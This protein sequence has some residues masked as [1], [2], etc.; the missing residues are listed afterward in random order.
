M[1][2]PARNRNVTLESHLGRKDLMCRKCRKSQ[3]AWEL[4][5]I[6]YICYSTSHKKLLVSGGSRTEPFTGRLSVVAGTLIRFVEIFFI[7]AHY[8]Q[9]S[10]D[11]RT[12]ILQ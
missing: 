5:S 12:L 10:S 4:P 1:K 9:S 2:E 6:S 8:D 11:T 3:R 7:D